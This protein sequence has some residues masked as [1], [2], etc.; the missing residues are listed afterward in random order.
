MSDSPKDFLYSNEA[1]ISYRCPFC[2]SCI[3]PKPGSMNCPECHA[4]FEYDD[5]MES[6]FVDTSDL[7][8]PVRG[9]VCPQCGLVQGMDGQ[10]CVYC[11]QGMSGTVQ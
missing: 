3:E 1:A 5:R 9:T 7:R 10:G 11:G 8:L 2:T 4:N 6:I